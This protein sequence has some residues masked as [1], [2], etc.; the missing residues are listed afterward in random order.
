MQQSKIDRVDDVGRIPKVLERNTTQVIWSPEPIP[1]TALQERTTGL[2]EI[3]AFEFCILKD[4]PEIM[5]DTSQE[6]YDAGDPDKLDPS[7]V[8]PLIRR[9]KTAGAI[10]NELVSA[11]G[12]RGL[13]WLDCLE[14]VPPDMIQ[15]FETLLIPEEWTVLQDLVG[16]IE[17][18]NIDAETLPGRAAAAVVDGLNLA[19]GWREADAADKLAEAQRARQGKQGRA[20]FTMVE[21]EYYRQ[22]GVELPEDFTSPRAAA[23]AAGQELITR[24]ELSDLLKQHGEVIARATSSVFAEQMAAL[25]RRVA[26]V[27]EPAEAPAETPAKKDKK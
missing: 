16:H 5:V 15:R 27:A 13:V 14:N 17:G 26:R 19:I 2:K 25:E 23:A 8:A 6:S 24:E 10:A 21:I 3:P 7:P 11:Y 1:H 20:T 9:V 18:L 4:V 12:D 22:A